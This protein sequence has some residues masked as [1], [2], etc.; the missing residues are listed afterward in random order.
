MLFPVFL[1]SL[2]LTS[3][4]YLLN[5]LYGKAMYNDNRALGKNTASFLKGGTIEVLKY[6]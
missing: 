6:Y 1:S 3:T 4:Y 2:F 5:L